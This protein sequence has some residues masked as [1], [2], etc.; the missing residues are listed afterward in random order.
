M[1]SA[2]RAYGRQGGCL[3]RC[4]L[5][6]RPPPPPF[7]RPDGRCRQTPAERAMN[8]ITFDT[9]AAAK[10][11]AQTGFEDRQAEAVTGVVRR[12][13]PPSR[14]QAC[15]PRRTRHEDRPRRPRTLRV[16]GAGSTPGGMAGRV[17]A[18]GDASRAIFPCYRR[19]DAVTRDPTRF[20]GGVGAAG[21]EHRGV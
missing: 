6:T 13:T 11:L 1:N 3:R 17:P 5:G 16:R 15:R 14:V 12:A 19:P 10:T 20:R 7:S 9:L 18:P 4:P 8:G 2:R 21:G